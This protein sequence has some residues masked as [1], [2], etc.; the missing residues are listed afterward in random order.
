MERPKTVL[1]VAK[2][3]NTT[4][5]ELTLP[6]NFCGRLLRA[7]EKHIYDKH[8]F[9]VRWQDGRPLG[10]CRRCIRLCGVLEFA[11]YFQRNLLAEDIRASTGAPVWFQ[12]IRCRRC[13]KPLSKKEKVL[14]QKRREFF[15]EVRGKLRAHCTLC[16]LFFGNAR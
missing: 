8:Y 12:Q 16:R 13:L 3:F 7:T 15:Y 14:L 5:E 11:L 10:C 4:V 2:L 1:E 9:K 6:C